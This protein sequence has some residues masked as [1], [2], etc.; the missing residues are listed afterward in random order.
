[1]AYFDPRRLFD[2]EGRIKK[3]TEIDDDTRAAIAS[4]DIDETGRPT[5]IKFW[6][7]I[8]AIDKAMKHLGLYEHDSTQRGEN[9]ALQIVLVKPG[10]R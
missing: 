6:N 8:D 2:E 10:D 9:L 1:M 5:R 4:F 3:I 7:K